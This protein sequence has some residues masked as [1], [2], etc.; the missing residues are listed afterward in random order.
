MGFTALRNNIGHIEPNMLTYEER[1]GLNRAGHI[2]T[3]TNQSYWLP[4]IPERQG[5]KPLLPMKF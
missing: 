4:L 2:V 3:I 5:G 1:Q